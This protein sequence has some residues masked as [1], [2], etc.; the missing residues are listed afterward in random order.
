MA[1]VKGDGR[2]QRKKERR[3]YGLAK[4]HTNVHSAEIL[5]VQNNS[6]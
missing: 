1:L 6:N 3:G 4:I 5:G 2:E